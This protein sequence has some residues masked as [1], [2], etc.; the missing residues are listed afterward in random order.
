MRIIKNN[1]QMS[2][3]GGTAPRQPPVPG[4]ANTPYAQRPPAFASTPRPD[5]GPRARPD[6][7]RSRRI[8]R[9][10]PPA[11]HHGWFS[12]LSSWV[13]AVPK[14]PG[15]KFIY[16]CNLLAHQRPLAMSVTIFRVRVPRPWIS[17]QSLRSWARPA[18]L[19]R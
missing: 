7:G 15:N 2:H 9:S 11:T 13:S 4:R 14:Y 16:Q 8:L 19:G 18:L 1:E 6:L 5:A 3:G 10:R 12:S 17:T